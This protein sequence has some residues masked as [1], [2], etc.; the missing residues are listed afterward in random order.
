MKIAAASLC[1]TLAVTTLC[2]CSD[3]GNSNP[4]EEPSITTE[5]EV[6]NAPTAEPTEEPSTEPE[7]QAEIIPL[8]NSMTVDDSGL[9]IDQLLSE[10]PPADFFQTDFVSGIGRYWF[11]SRT[12]RE[13]SGNTLYHLDLP[14]YTENIVLSDPG[15]ENAERVVDICFISASDNSVVTY[16]RRIILEYEF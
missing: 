13:V 9:T 11:W 2:A 1:L 12:D 5:E 10:T 8:W 7:A 16:I 6:T 3:S 4:S 14:M 15:S